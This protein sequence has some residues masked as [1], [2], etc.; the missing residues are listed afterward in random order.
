MHSQVGPLFLD[1]GDVQ[2]RR[3]R[4][5]WPG[6]MPL[7]VS[8][9]S[10]VARVWIGRIARVVARRGFQ[11]PSFRHGYVHVLAVDTAVAAHG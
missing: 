11:G 3:Y 5:R 2:G 6:E 8:P 1:L 7:G 4:G 9:L 10:N